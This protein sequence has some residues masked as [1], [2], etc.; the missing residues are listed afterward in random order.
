MVEEIKMV[1]K[2]DDKTLTI[3]PEVLEEEHTT[4]NKAEIFYH[5][6]KVDLNQQDGKLHFKHMT[7]MVKVYLKH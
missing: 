2:T 3:V 6:T 5:N 4:K 1:T 7:S